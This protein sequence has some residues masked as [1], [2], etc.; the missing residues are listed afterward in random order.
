MVVSTF[1]ADFCSRQGS[2]TTGTLI[3]AALLASTFL[4]RC[5]ALQLALGLAARSSPPSRTDILKIIAILL[6]AAGLQA[7][8]ENIIGVLAPDERAGPRLVVAA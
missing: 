7:R 6:E 1:S 8:C 3:A 5:E 4:I 2:V